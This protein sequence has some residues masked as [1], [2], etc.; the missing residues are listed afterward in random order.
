MSTVMSIIKSMT[1]DVNCASALFLSCGVSVSDPQELA[2]S[3]KLLEVTQY[4]STCVC[5]PHKF[6]VSMSLPLCV[7]VFVCLIF[8]KSHNTCQPVSVCL[9]SSVCLS[10]RV[11]LC[12]CVAL[13]TSVYSCFSVCMSVQTILVNLCL[14]VH[15]IF[16][17]LCPSA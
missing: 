5:Q 12:A 17:N 14:S 10:P 13:S 2:V 16:V 4:L 3:W 1:S 6:R 7:R 15:T 8:L 9:T 11:C